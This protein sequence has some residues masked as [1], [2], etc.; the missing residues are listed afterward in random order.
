MHCGHRFINTTH[1]IAANA[2]LNHFRHG[3]ARK[4]NHRRA[5]RHRLNHHQAERF[6]PVDGKQQR[7]RIAKEGGFFMLVDLAN[8][9]DT[10]VRRYQWADGVLPVVAV[11]LV[12]LGG[13]LQ[14]Q[15]GAYRNLDGMVGTLLRRNP[16]QKRQVVAA[17]IS[18]AGQQIR[19]QAVV[20]G[21][22]PVHRRHRR[23]LRGGN[24]H[25]R[26]MREVCVERLQVGQVQAAMQGGHGPHRHAPQQRKVDHVDMEVQHVKA[27]GTRHDAV[28]HHHVIRQR[29]A[30][31]R[32][33]AQRHVGA[34][35]Q[36][37][38]RGRVPTCEQRDVMALPHQ[39]F[40]EVGNDA[41]RAA[42][43]AG[44]A[45]LG[46]WCNLRNLHRH[47]RVL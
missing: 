32:I 23:A 3:A 43:E 21:A 38:T 33:Q 6:R 13:N 19:R 30:H 1:D 9:F 36:F 47:P 34:R 8:V 14:R 18:A 37:G 5:A 4:R 12:D 44:R 46:K 25:Q 35:Y 10:R 17:W 28:Q 29:I 15:P 41:L 2:R 45:A 16:A 40:G 24:R 7:A 39:F 42:I 22:G 20:H 27:A 11:D 31:A 26:E